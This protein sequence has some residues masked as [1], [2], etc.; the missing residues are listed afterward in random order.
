MKSKTGTPKRKKQPVFSTKAALLPA[1]IS[2]CEQEYK[3]TFGHPWSPAKLAWVESLTRQ[4]QVEGE[5]WRVM[6]EF[7]QVA[8]KALVFFESRKLNPYKPDNGLFHAYRLHQILDQY[9]PLLEAL[10]SDIRGNYERPPDRRHWL[11][12]GMNLAK[13]NAFARLP[14]SLPYG[15]VLSHRE[16]AL[17]SILMTGGEEVEVKGG[18]TVSGAIEQELRRMARAAE[19]APL[20]GRKKTRTRRVAAPSSDGEDDAAD[21]SQ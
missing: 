5:A 20:R 7:R 9:R 15:R 18:I 21:L 16:L 11:A 3:G 4:W 1:L 17:L 13:P 19:R 2:Q 8:E 6:H 14:E 12:W 10:V